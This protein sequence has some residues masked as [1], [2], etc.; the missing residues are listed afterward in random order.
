MREPN[1][2]AAAGR[3]C[4]GALSDARHDAGVRV[5][6]IL[7]FRGLTRQGIGLAHAGDIVGIAGVTKAIVAD[8]LCASQVKE[9]LPVQPI[10]PPTISVTFGINDGPLAG[11]D[12]HKV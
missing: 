6:T 10:D 1:P 8:T 3:Q 7:A 12:A 11:R 4:R 2:R 9:A 5:S